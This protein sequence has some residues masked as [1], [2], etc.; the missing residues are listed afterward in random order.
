MLSS[1]SKQS[2]ESLESVLKCEY[3][4]HLVVISSVNQTCATV[5][6]WVQE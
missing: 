2:G 1:I 5:M 6:Y 3:I 4:N